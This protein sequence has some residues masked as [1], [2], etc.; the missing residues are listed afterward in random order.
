[1][2]CIRELKIVYW[3]SELKELIV[4]WNSEVSSSTLISFWSEQFKIVTLISIG[5]HLIFCKPSEHNLCIHHMF[6]VCYRQH[7]VQNQ[8]FLWIKRGRKEGCWEEGDVKF[9]LEE[10]P[11]KYLAIHYKKYLFLFF[12]FC[13]K[14]SC[15]HYF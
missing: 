6:T 3:K 9:N 8:C 14:D 2:Y 13:Q 11:T 4:Y 1:M 5:F 7:N 15:I 12:A 10:P